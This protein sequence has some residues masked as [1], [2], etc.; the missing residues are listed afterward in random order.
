VTPEIVT[1]EHIALY[2]QDLATRP[3]P[4]GAN[5]LTLDSGRGLSNSTMQQRLTVARLYHDYLV[6]KQLRLDHPI[7]R[8][9]F[10]P[11]L[12]GECQPR[13]FTFFQSKSWLFTLTVNT[14]FSWG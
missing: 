7:A 10:V 12:C 9:H 1:R 2:V 8:G 6:E 5:I 3:N 13:P 4:K 14:N 11:Y